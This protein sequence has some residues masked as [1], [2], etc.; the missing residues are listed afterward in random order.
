MNVRERELIERARERLGEMTVSVSH[1]DRGQPVLDESERRL[2]AV[3]DLLGEVL[4]RPDEDQMPPGWNRP[5]AASSDDLVEVMADVLK[6]VEEDASPE[7]FIEW[8][9]P[10][11]DPCDTCGGSG[12]QAEADDQWYPVSQVRGTVGKVRTC[13]RCG[14]SG[15]QWHQSEVH[16]KDAEF[17][18]RAI[19]R[20][21]GCG[22]GSGGM[23]VF[24]KD[25]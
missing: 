3:W 24:R 7:G 16:L 17:G 23:R 25:D 10:V 19:Y 8:T 5:A 18:L 14:G 13:E 2:R 9:I 11:P 20:V 1:N 4:H 6:L 15:Q 12:E 21:G 22:P